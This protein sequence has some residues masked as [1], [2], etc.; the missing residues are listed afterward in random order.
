VQ[1]LS[2]AA[3]LYLL[4]GLSTLALG[5]VIGTALLGSSEMVA[6]GHSLHDRGAVVVEET[7]RLALLFEEQ[8]QVVRRAP[9]EIDLNRLKEYRTRFDELSEKLSAH[10]T[11]LAPLAATLT[12]NNAS[13]LAALFGEFRAHAAAIFDFAQDFLQDK[14][15]EVL[16][17]PQSTVAGQIDA[18]LDELLNAAAKT[19]DDE[20][21]ALSNARDKMVWTIAAVSLLGVV[22]FIGLGIYLARRLTHQLGWIIA[23]MSALS[24]GD[25]DSQLAAGG[26]PDEI[27]AMARALEVFR[28]EMIASRQMAAELRR[29][30]E[31]LAHAQRIAHMG[32]DITNLR[33]DEAEWSDELYSIFGV[34]RET[35]VTSTDNFLRMVH[36]DDRALVLATREKIKD[37]IC[38][39][40]FEYR[41]VRPDGSVRHIYREN[42]FIR[43]EAGSPFFLTGTCQD[44]SEIRAAQEREKELE[45]QLMHSQKLEALGTLAGG[46]AHDL[47]NT[48]V[49]IL[50]LSKLAL[51]ELPPNSPVHGDIETIA[52]ASE[53]ARDLVKKIL[54]FSRKQ[55]L[56]K[57]EVDL[58]RV[59]R[60]ALQMLRA[61]VP[62]TI[63]IVD[64][65]LEVPPLFG[66]A[67]E[68][69]QVI[70]NLVT[71]AAQAIGGGVGKITVTLWTTA[72]QQSSPRDEARPAVCLSIADTGCGMDEAT[73]GRVFEPFFTTKGVGDGTGLGLSMVHGI[74]TRHGGRIT[75]HSQPGEGSEFILWLPAVTQLQTVGNAEPAA[76]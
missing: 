52:R 74:V 64:Q 22:T 26:D 24:A 9:A 21:E 47:N 34:T 59:T 42:E 23:E 76:A 41:I 3:R 49:P 19:T 37:G 53:R 8:E 33:T 57:Q 7:S 12:A 25:L 56:V 32:S 67:G 10:L 62:A 36:P 61:S 70:V 6:A 2:I 55:D 43:N 14:A 11:R 5:L 75:I 63:Q 69:H 72:G 31:H 65:I 4:V 20:V 44:I 68:L 15:R 30:Q 1:R 48:L 54:A 38:P 16:D 66:D 39:D 51:D 50:A 73:V 35:Y 45:R 58:A 27:G 60:D 29:S 40:P 18:I 17:G 71:N 46:V 28:F 13:R